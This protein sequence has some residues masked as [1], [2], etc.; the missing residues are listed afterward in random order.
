MS[1]KL[2]NN[3]QF[4]QRFV[5]NIY[6]LLQVLMIL[7]KSEWY[8]WQTKHKECGDGSQQADLPPLEHAVFALIYIRHLIGGDNVFRN[9]CKTYMRF[10][11]ND[12]KNKYIKE[13]LQAFNN[14]LNNCNDIPIDIAEQINSVEELLNVMMYGTLILHAPSNVEQ[15]YREKYAQLSGH[16][17]RVSF[18]WGIDFVMRQIFV[19]IS[20]ACN[21]FYTD[22]EDWVNE[23]LIPKPTINYQT[24]FFSWEPIEE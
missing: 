24:E 22:L 8:N 21:V 13:Q 3:E 18:L 12:S 19:L 10:V 17:N 20:G 7:Q 15:K 6:H 4:E 16:K 5:D 2:K 1:E 11:D 9:A 14:H 23:G